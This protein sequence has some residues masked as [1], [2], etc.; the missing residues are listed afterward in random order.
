MMLT[1]FRFCDDDHDV[2]DDDDDD[3]DVD[4]GDDGERDG[5][6]DETLC[7]LH[8]LKPNLRKRT[9]H[10]PRQLPITPFEV[11]R[12]QRNLKKSHHSQMESPACIQPLLRLWLA[13]PVLQLPLEAIRHK[14][15]I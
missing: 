6:D 4:D 15:F 11:K 5:D 12:S 3:D 14:G 1:E 9:S 8:R 7:I 13:K 10:K 2:D